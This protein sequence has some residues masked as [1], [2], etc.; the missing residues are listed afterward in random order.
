VN[1]I[2]AHDLVSDRAV[3]FCVTHYWV[4]SFGDGRESDIWVAPW[5]W[6]FGV[7]E[8]P[9]PPNNQMYWRR[10]VYR[11]IIERQQFWDECRDEFL[12]CVSGGERQA[13]N[14]RYR[15][16]ARFP[17]SKLNLFERVILL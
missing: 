3:E 7:E 4:C 6:F 9:P 17:E 16:R 8:P 13:N 10:P 5:S 1:P 2:E 11:E 12:R 15:R 14:A